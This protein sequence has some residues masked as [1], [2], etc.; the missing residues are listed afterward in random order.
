MKQLQVLLPI[1]LLL[2][3]GLAPELRGQLPTDFYEELWD[4]DFDRVTGVVFDPSGRG[5][6]WERNGLVHRLDLNG[7]RLPVP[8]LDIREEV[9]DWWDMGMVGFALDPDFETNGH[10][11][12]L[13]SVD[14]H[15]LLNFGT[16]T[17]DPSLTITNEATIGRITRYTADPLTDFTTLKPDSRLVLVGQT[18][19]DGFPVL[20]KTHGPGALV[21]GTDGTLLAS[22]GD[23]GFPD[24]NDLGSN[25]N[26][27]YEQA[28]EDG[29]LQ[30]KENIGA[31]RAQ[32]IDNLNG[33]IIRI[34]PQT[35]AGL[36]SNPFYDPAAPKAARSRIWALGLRNPFK[37][38]HKPD[39]GSH[40]PGDGDPGT[41]LVADVGAN[42]WEEVNVL[43][44]PG[45]NFGWPL[46]E[47]P[48]PNPGFFDE[49]IANLDAPNPLSGC[50]PAF[51]FFR[52]LLQPDQ[53][54]PPPA[55]NPCDET[56]EI[57]AS[58][59][60]FV[61]RRPAVAYRNRGEEP[62][63]E[64]LIPR[65]DQDG[66]AVAL[67][68][69]NPDSGVEGDPFEGIAS[70]TGMYVQGA[71]LPL[72]YQDRYL[73]L[74]FQG[75]LKWLDFD[76]SLELVRVEPF[77]E[78]AENIVAIA[79]HPLDG[80]W[81]W[82]DI[83]AKELRRICYGG[84]PGPVPVINASTQFGPAPLT[85]EFSGANSTTATEYPLD[86]FWEFGDGATSTEMEPTH[87]FTSNSGAPT[88][89]EVALTVTDSAGQSRST[90]LIISLNNTPPQVEITSI[91]EG[92][93]YPLSSSTL[94]QLR[95]FATDLEFAESELQYRW[96]SF[97]HHDTHEHTGLVSQDRSTY[98]IVS[99]LGCGE[100]TYWYRIELSVT[101]P[102]GLTGRDTRLIY[103]WCGP[104]FPEALTLEG[105]SLPDRILL[106]WEVAAETEVLRYEV[107]RSADFLYFETLAEVEAEHGT[108]RPAGYAIWDE[109]PLLGD[110]IY[111][112]KA[113]HQDGAIAFSE[114]AII[115]WPLASNLVF[116]PNP[117]QQDLQFKL[118]KA[119]AE[120]VEL[121]LFDAT[122]RR[123]LQKQLAAMPKEALEA[124]VPE[125]KNL[126]RG[127]YFYR[128]ENG[129]EVLTGKLLAR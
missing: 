118:F 80:C 5:F 61:H 23:M 47:G 70:I 92:L 103:P 2:F 8:L 100:E 77:F 84:I 93:Q 105:E 112:I 63:P 126:P 29:I 110:N 113:W 14:R 38:L 106:K 1:L 67:S 127:L 120:V 128:F 28:L 115:P 65:Y 31:F 121:E 12:L 59:P 52:H 95:G 56:Q 125:V 72:A 74:D 27:Y 18:L 24:D 101:D 15:H 109:A 73:H 71:Q 102:A 22:C 21:F 16:P 64:V 94:L 51:F 97:L 25:H 43:N 40:F 7:E 57:P 32:L 6:V 50:E 129:P 17:Y 117:F 124:T 90:V 42:E 81:Y 85:V 53:L 30:P 111:R 34:D 116:F 69:T 60:T 107:Q 119:R 96:E 86:F 36:P 20:F 58:I 79:E 87:T 46:Y 44:G 48:D 49:P 35:G 83:R 9:A 68:I 99:P 13:Y 4:D 91:P 122:G 39:T 54:T 45:Q 114:L 41:F 62:N 108:A 75:W 37:F 3:W 104:E 26:T 55:L 88:P 76:E 10:F 89:F 123:V 33:K 98:M 19:S 11:Y 82:V 78:L 66:Q